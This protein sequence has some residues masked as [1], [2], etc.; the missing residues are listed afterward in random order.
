MNLAKIASSLFLIIFMAKS[1]DAGGGHHNHGNEH[2][3]PIDSAATDCNSYCEKCKFLRT[4]FEN[5]L[6]QFTTIWFNYIE[7]GVSFINKQEKRGRN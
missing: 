1:C 7:H 2:D 3:A 4:I 5:F 6:M